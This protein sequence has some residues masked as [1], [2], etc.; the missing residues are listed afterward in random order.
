MKKLFLLCLMLLLPSLAHA[1]SA[2]YV[3]GCVN[4]IGGAGATVT[5]NY[6]TSQASGSLLVIALKKDNTASDPLTFT[7]SVTGATGTCNQVG[8]LSTQGILYSTA[9]AACLLTGAGTPVISVTWIGSTSDTFLSIVSGSYTATSGFTSST[10]DVFTASVN[11]TST[12]CIT[13]TSAATVNANELVV[14]TCDNWNTA[15]TYGTTPTGYSANRTASSRNTT[16]WFDKSV[17]ATG[18]QSGTATILSDVSVGAV[19]SF[20]LNSGGGA[21][22][23]RGKAVIF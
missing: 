16:G 5:C 21:A 20:Q 22:A 12:S 23:T 6:T 3:A 11:A 18:T 8:T 14:F 17:T 7:A 13:G 2:T 1:V 15:Q 4:E 9:Y 19:M 10:A